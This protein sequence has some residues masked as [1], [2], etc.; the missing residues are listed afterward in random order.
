MLAIALDVSDRER[1]NEVANRDPVMDKVRTNMMTYNDTAETRWYS[2][3][4][5]TFYISK[6]DLE[7]YLAKMHCVYISE[8]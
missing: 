2:D 4:V 3:K 6:P 5:D 7:R 1:I 8:A